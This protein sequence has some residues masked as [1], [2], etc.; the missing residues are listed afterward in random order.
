MRIL[1]IRRDNIG[2]LVCTTP[3]LAALRGRYPHAHV[4]ALVN[5]YNAAV[6]DGN[7]HLDAVHSYTKLKHRAQGQSR[8]GILYERLRMLARLRRE[9][10]EYVVLAK[11]SFDRQG[12]SLARQLKHR[13]VVGFLPPG[14]AAMRGITRGVAAPDPGMH[15]VQFLQCL[16][17][18]LDVRDAPGPTRVYPRA[19]RVDKW[20]A[21][22]AGGGWTAVHISAREPGRRWPVARWVDLIGRLGPDA[23][24]ALMWAPGAQS[25]PRHPGDDEIAAAI[26]QQVKAVG[27][28]T[29]ELADLIAALSLCDRFVGVDGGAMHLAA[30]L[31]LPTVALFENVADKQ[32]HWHPWQVTHELI[33]PRTRDIADISVEAVI[34]ALQRLAA[35]MAPPER[36]AALPQSQA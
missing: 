28:P 20:R 32:R 36:A 17:E 12:L 27:V 9:P 6:L 14:Q 21:R 16:G 30:A 18:K 15:E 25:D 31:G 4:A 24:V 33:A 19:E 8:V 29:Q 13:H 22:L 3:L 26:L 10:Y 2:D 34:L 7:P 35:R 23:R 11:S 5:S 1:V